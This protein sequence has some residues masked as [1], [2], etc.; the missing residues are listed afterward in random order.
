MGQLSL[1][2]SSGVL[3]ILF[4]LY[5]VWDVL[6]RD[7]G[8][9]TMVSISR[10]VQE[11]AR[12]FLKREYSTVSILVLVVAGLMTATGVGLLRWPTVRWSGWLS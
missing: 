8:N 12:A 10:L 11:G 1:A 9:E 5:L 7:P 4:V 3:G 2:L 6:R